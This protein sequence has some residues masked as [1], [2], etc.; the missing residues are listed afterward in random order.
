MGKP[1]LNKLPI[2]RNRQVG[3]LFYEMGKILAYFTKWAISWIGRNI[4]ILCFALY[5]HTHKEFN[6]QIIGI[7][8]ILIK[9][10]SFLMDTSVKMLRFKK[11]FTDFIHY[12]FLLSLNI[13]RLNDTT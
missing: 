11:S 10:L 1:Q 4:Y 12:A 8:K 2:S 6:C 9:Y 3:C 5:T 7:N 13:I